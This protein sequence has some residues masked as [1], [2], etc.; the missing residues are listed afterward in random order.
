MG[1]SSEWIGFVT[2][3]EYSAMLST[4]E[5]MIDGGAEFPDQVFAQPGG[6]IVFGEHLRVLTAQA[7]ESLRALASLHGDDR[8]DIVA[9]APSNVGYYIPRF[10]RPLAISV[11]ATATQRE[12]ADALQ[13]RIDPSWIDSLEDTTDRVAVFGPSGN[14]AIVTDHDLD[15]AAI[16]SAQPSEKFRE[17]QRSVDPLLSAA[18]ALEIASGAYGGTLPTG[19]ARTFLANYSVR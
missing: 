19:F 16:W 3:A 5:R 8:V 4:L 14:W 10:G 1:D 15:I 13:Q 17:W 11:P 2:D 9:L 18:D 6:R 12:F 7:W